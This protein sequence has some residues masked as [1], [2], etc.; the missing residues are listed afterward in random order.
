MPLLQIKDEGAPLAQ[1]ELQDH[2]IIGR[3]PECNV[4][5][6]EPHASRRHAEFLN[7]A[8]GWYVIDLDTRNGT[9]VN[10][11]RIKEH[12]L[13]SG[14][15]I[16]IGKATL[17]FIDET[18]AVQKRGE[19][20]G[21]YEIT[22]EVARSSYSRVC[23][24]YRSG[25][26]KEMLM[27]ILDRRAFGEGIENLL[28][29]VRA[30]TAVNHPA[31]ATIYE[32]N[33][34]GDKPYFVSEYVQGRTLAEVIGAEGR[35]APDRAKSIITRVAEGLLVAHCRG[36]VHGNLK[37]KN[38]M[39]GPGGE[40]KLVD[41]G[42]LCR[43]GRADRR[44]ANLAV[45]GGVPYY[46]APE[47]ILNNPVDQRSD[48]YSLGAVFYSMLTGAPLFAGRTDEEIMQKHLLEK[49]DDLSRY[50][51]GMPA[52][53]RRVVERMLA[54]DPADRYQGMQEFLNALA[55]KALQP[56]MGA[57]ADARPARES[58]GERPSSPTLAFSAGILF[59]LL[60]V[61]I[62]LGARDLGQIAKQAHQ[63]I[64]T[65]SHEDR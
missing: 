51:P 13:R 39:I 29:T 10:G 40:V 7:R 25:S 65:T 49:P 21:D 58:A 16:T 27:K 4:Q 55:G 63:R 43:T 23:R 8:D 62:F 24:V 6:R 28:S 56:Q 53:L 41:F 32:V 33:P 11:E 17:T 54:K 45:F 60:L 42:G 47:Q 14:D 26:G 1:V 12:C 38:I 46:V 31:I 35:I 2:T 37:P 50:V 52:E 18:L 34:R 15:V 61:A 36:I 30:L 19:M 5:L 44:T 48:V 57:A 3:M 20:V 9:Q 64:F 22:E 59:I